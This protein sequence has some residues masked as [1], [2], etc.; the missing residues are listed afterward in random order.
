LS[1]RLL[2]GVCCIGG[3]VATAMGLGAA[4][5]F[6]ALMERYQ[7]YF[8]L[9]GVAVMLLWLARRLRRTGTSPRDFRAVVRVL[10]RPALVMAVVYGLSLGIATGVVELVTT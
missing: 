6:G 3:L 1:S 4:G 7:L 5:F 8:V 2:S 10:G 9:A